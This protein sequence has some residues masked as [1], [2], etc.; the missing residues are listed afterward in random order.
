[1]VLSLPILAYILVIWIKY[2]IANVIENGLQEV[3]DFI[4]NQM[5]NLFKIRD[6]F[7]IFK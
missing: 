2:S 4:R 1:M 7:S 6:M 5:Q 3:K